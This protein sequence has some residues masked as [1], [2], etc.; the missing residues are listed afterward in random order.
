M[1][2]PSE[3]IHH[4]EAVLHIA[5]VKKTFRYSNGFFYNPYTA[6]HCFGT[7]LWKAV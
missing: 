7:L 5:V 6:I 2:L 1:Q 4:A 3:Y